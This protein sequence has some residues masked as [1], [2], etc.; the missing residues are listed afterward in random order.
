[1][2]DTDSRANQGSANAITDR[3]TP[4]S[5]ETGRWY[6]IRVEFTPDSIKCYLDGKLTNQTR[7]AT[8][9]MLFASAGRV[10][11]SNEIVVKIVNGSDKEKPLSLNFAKVGSYQGTMTVLTSK[12]ST[13][14][15]SLDEPTKVS[16]YSR[17]VKINPTHSTVKCPALSVTVLRLKPSV[18][19]P[20]GIR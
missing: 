6:D 1:M 19:Q 16:P 15:N 7:P 12:S 2:S 8:T 11:A 5:V 4:G 9:P 10:E 14:E 17:S 3:G 13:D 18:G 20:G